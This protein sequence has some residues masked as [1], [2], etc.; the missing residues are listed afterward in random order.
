MRDD[1]T[2]RKEDG[3][4]GQ[5]FS[6]IYVIEGRTQKERRKKGKRRTQ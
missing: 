4:T 3:W 1:A 6:D 5:R 2:G